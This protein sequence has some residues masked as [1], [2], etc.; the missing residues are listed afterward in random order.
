ME[1]DA[2]KIY[3]QWEY[4]PANYFEQ[5]VR[6]DAN[7]FSGFIKDGTVQVH[8]KPGSVISDELRELVAEEV[9]VCFQTRKMLKR[10]PYNLN[11]PVVCTETVSGTKRIMFTTVVDTAISGSIDFTVVDSEGNVISD[12]KKERIERESHFLDKVT[13]G[14]GR[15]KLVRALVQSY[16]N[17]VDDSANELIYLGEISEALEKEF[18]KIS[19]VAKVLGVEQDRIGRLYNLS[20]KDG[21]STGRH[22]GRRITSLSK[23]PQEEISRARE[24]AKELIAAYASFVSGEGNRSE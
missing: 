17:S 2:E 12:S 21:I 10:A 4:T 18:G 22:R 19:L 11:G 20:S 9:K 6:I 16:S 5:E 1:N 8:P 24:V 14:A 13:R 23:P 15:S 3:F 7:E